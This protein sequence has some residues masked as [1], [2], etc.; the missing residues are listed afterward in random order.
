MCRQNEKEL[1]ALPC[2]YAP[3]EAEAWSSVEDLL[4]IIKEK[5]SEEQRKTIWIDEE[6][7]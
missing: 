1:E 2:L 3:L 6:Q 7:L 5:V 4:R